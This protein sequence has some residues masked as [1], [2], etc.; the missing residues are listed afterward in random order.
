MKAE[1]KAKVGRRDFLRALGAGAGVAVAAAGPLATS[2]RADS[3]S[4]AGEDEG[5]LSG[6]RAREGVLSGQQ[7]SQR[8]L[9]EGKRSCLS[10]KVNVRPA[11]APLLPR[12]RA[13]P[14]AASTAAPS[15]AAPASPP[16]GLA[17]LGA[18]PLG[19]RAQGGG[20]RRTG[21]GQRHHPPEHLHALLGRLHRPGRGLERRVGRA[22][23]PAG[24][25]RSAAARTAPRAPRRARSRMATAA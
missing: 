10:R 17:A 9:R 18:L 25:A 23:S 22:R 6:D 4:N 2:A 11:A 8:A 24:T 20:R 7:I 16:A 3:E 15:C 13:K 5:P 21:A 19:R 1:G 14:A 12:L